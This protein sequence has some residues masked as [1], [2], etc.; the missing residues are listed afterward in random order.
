MCIE[1]FRNFVEHLLFAKN[2]MYNYNELFEIIRRSKKLNINYNLEI[3]HC[4][5]ESPVQFLLYVKT[6]FC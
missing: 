6:I 1:M 3:N 4:V 5:Y 2:M